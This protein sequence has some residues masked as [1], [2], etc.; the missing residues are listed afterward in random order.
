MN[1]FMQLLLAFLEGLLLGVFFF[2]GLLWTVRRLHSSK[3][4]ALLFLGSLLLRTS[5][6][7]LGFY[8]ILG[9]NWLHL[10]AGVIG[11]VNARILLTRLT[12]PA[13]ELKNI[14]KVDV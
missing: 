14:D 12:R 1:E 8:F 4:L 5:I 2:A 9:D 10:V 3:Q 7:M 6:V 11:F 13:V